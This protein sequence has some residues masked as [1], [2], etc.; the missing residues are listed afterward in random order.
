MMRSRP[1]PS[2]RRSSDR[3]PAVMAAVRRHQERTGKQVMVAFNIRDETDAMRRHAD[4]V[5]K[6]GGSCVMASLNWCGF[7]AIETLR[8]TPTSPST[9]T[10][11]AMARC[12]A[13]PRSAS[14]FRPTKRCG[15]SPASITCMSMAWRE[16]SL[17]TTPKSSRAPKSA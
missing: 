16:N 17:R 10:A 15:G 2:T 4:L 5:A 12:R 6:E 14:A 7:S 13:I 1:T 11:T 8:R 9:A 3:I